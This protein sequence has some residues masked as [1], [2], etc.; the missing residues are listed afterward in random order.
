MYSRYEKTS[1]LQLITVISVINL[2]FSVFIIIFLMFSIYFSLLYFSLCLSPIVSQL[3]P[4]IT[5]LKLFATIWLFKY[6][7]IQQN[8]FYL[9]KLTQDHLG[10]SA[11][12]LLN[13]YVLFIIIINYHM[14]QSVAILQ[15]IYLFTCFPK[16]FNCLHYILFNFWRKVFF[17]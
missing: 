8:I 13:L 3:N 4:E 5:I 15:N 11:Q 10:S 6:S 1:I 17:C 16:H 9:A 12:V 7:L 14:H 2:L